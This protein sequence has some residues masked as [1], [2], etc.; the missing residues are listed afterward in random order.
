MNM[1]TK[2]FQQGTSLCIHHQN[3]RNKLRNNHSIIDC[4]ILRWY[5]KVSRRSWAII[6]R[7][8][9]TENRMNLGMRLKSTDGLLI[10]W[11]G[12]SILY[13]EI[14]IFPHLSHTESGVGPSQPD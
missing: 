9:R 7:N 14:R 13:L 8:V 4:R 1:L 5:Q 10:V 6:S 12:I 3:Q 2:M 11:R